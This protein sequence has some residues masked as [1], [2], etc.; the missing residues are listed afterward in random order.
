M[1]NA[2]M[3]YRRTVLA[4]LMAGMMAMGSPWLANPADSMR[5][6]LQGEPAADLFS[7]LSAKPWEEGAIWEPVEIARAKCLKLEMARNEKESI[8]LVVHAMEQPVRDVRLELSSLVN[9][10]GDVFP[11]ERIDIEAVGYIDT[12]SLWLKDLHLGFWPDPLL[13][14]KEAPKAILPGANQ[15]YWLRFRTAADTPPGVYRGQL[16][17]TAADDGARIF[18]VEV[19]VWAFT[20][21]REQHFT[22]S[23]PIWSDAPELMHENFGKPESTRKL[24]EI[25]AEYRLSPFPLKGDEIRFMGERGQRWFCM[26]TFP[27]DRAPNDTDRELIA[28][29]A[30]IWRENAAAG[31]TPYVLL[32]DE[33]QPDQWPFIVE[34]GRMVRELFPEAVRCNTL[35]MYGKV[36]GKVEVFFPEDYE[37]RYLSYYEESFHNLKDGVDLFIIGAGR[38]TTVMDSVPL[39]ASHGL[40]LWWYYVCDWVYIPAPGTQTRL[41]PWIHWRYGIPGFLHWGMVFWDGENDPARPNTAGIDGKKWPDI[42]WNGSGSR[43]GDGYL[44][45]PARDGA[46]FWPSIRMENLRDGIEDYEYFFLLQK[47]VAEADAEGGTVPADVRELLQIRPELIASP[48]EYTTDPVALRSTRRRLGDAIERMTAAH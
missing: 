13:P 43:S 12:V 22:S 39:A 1:R 10:A 29:K 36:P 33:P 44:V 18:P 42:P 21:P 17:V 47:L 2:I 45:Y 46:G 48:Y 25:M 35:S 37:K 32:G 7:T 19:K 5:K 41:M 23:I 6:V 15:S 11:A 38:G 40:K 16:T 27:K 24:L 4:C 34:Q 20:L 3:N 30:K 26:H 14:L 28:Q 8:Q 31:W 9:A